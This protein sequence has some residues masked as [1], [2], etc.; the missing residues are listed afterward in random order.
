MG[1]RLPRR[2]RVQ[3]PDGG[4]LPTPRLD[5]ARGIPEPDQRRLNAVRRQRE[6]AAALGP[7][8]IGILERLLIRDLSWRELARQAGHG[9]LTD[10]QG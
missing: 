1:P 8:R 10:R 3:Q 2:R 7:E 9:L 6:T 5:F 4:R